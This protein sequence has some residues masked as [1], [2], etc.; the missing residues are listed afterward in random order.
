LSIG[1]RLK[2]L[3]EDKKISLED[4]AKKLDVPVGCLK[5]VEQGKRE[6]EKELVTKLAGLLG[7][8]ETYFPAT[9]WNAGEKTANQVERLSDSVGRKIRKLRE[10]RGLTLVDLGRKAGVSYTHISE[11]ERGNTC[12][13]L[14]TIDK[15]AN[16]LEL[17]VTFFFSE[18]GVDG[19]ENQ[20]GGEGVVGQRQGLGCLQGDGTAGEMEFVK[21]MLELVNQYKGDHLI[22]TDLIKKEIIEILSDLS[23]DKKRHLLEYA[24]FLKSKD[25]E[26]A[27]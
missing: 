17:P 4:L 27:G 9:D 20:P 6:M 12:P 8:P 25:E 5:E 23:Q 19:A 18:E 24:K 10:E 26:S 1:E 2:K 21:K 16:V 7:V 15:L 14:K 3:R 11:I 22:G 13:S